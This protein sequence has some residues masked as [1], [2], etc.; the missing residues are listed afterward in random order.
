VS[1]PARGSD[2]STSHE[3]AASVDVRKSQQQVLELLQAG[4]AID[5]WLLGRAMAAGV[6]MSPSGLRTR[7]KELVDMGR[8]IDTG[9]R[10]KTTSGR[11]S[12]VWALR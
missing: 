11:S 1:A 7:R 2:P 8:V 3:A 10:H 6:W 12:I 5:D 4:P 9:E